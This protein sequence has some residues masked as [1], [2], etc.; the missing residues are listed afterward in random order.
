MSVA[1]TSASTGTTN[2]PKHR[3]RKGGR[4]DSYL[5]CK[6][7]LLPG[8]TLKDVMFRLT[9][10][11]CLARRF[12][13]KVADVIA[14]CGTE[15]VIREMTWGGSLHKEHIVRDMRIDANKQVRYRFSSATWLV[16]WSS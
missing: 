16:G 3:G 14:V 4:C 6:H 10:E 15:S 2:L 8:H 5:R 13:T 1:A 12:P 7:P 11:V 9:P